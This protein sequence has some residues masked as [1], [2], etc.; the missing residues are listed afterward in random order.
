MSRHAASER[1]RASAPPLATY[2]LQFRNGFSFRD[3]ERLVPYLHDLGIS[4]VYCSP[5]L[6]ARPGS[7][8]G[9]DI[10]DHNALDPELGDEEDFASFVAALKRHG[11]GQ[12]LDFVPNHAGI[13]S[14]ENAW[15]HDV[16]EYGRA[17]PFA[18][19]FDIDWEPA[20][21]RLR[22]RVLLPFL[23][24]PYGEILE[25][26]ELRLV[27]D[28]AEGTFRASYHEHRFPI[29]PRDYARSLAPSLTALIERLGSQHGAVA[30]VR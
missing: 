26:G 3:A 27:F 6:R 11:M 21:S 16:L 13:G 14:A 4:H 2:R 24:D 20:L 17:S 29:R 12:I 30:R 23:G 8:H 28:A 15:W 19:F 1:P 10:V 7:S 25:R 5:Y 18:G 22:G 9:Y